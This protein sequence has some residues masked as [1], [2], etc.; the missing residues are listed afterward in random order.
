M[1]Q[2]ILAAALALASSGAA[3]GADPKPEVIHWWT[4]SSEAAAVR[5]IAD[6]YRAAGGVWTD[7]AIAGAD[8]ARAVAVN[9]IVGGN[10]P[11]AAQFNTTKQFTDL[12]EQGMLN[13][14]DDVALREGWDKFL[15]EPVLNV[16][17]VKGHYY[18][19]P[20]N[21]HMQAWI[22][23]SKAA[24]QKAGIS[25]EPASVDELFAALDKLKAAGII[26][27]A[28]GGQ[29]WQENILFLSML[30][31]MGGTDLY[32]KVL[33]ERDPAAINSE[34]FRRVLLNFKRLQSYVDP[35]APGRNWN[36]AT[37]L[38]I[39]GKAGV[40]VMGDWAKGE[41]SAA[42][43]SAGKDYGCI[44]GFGPR[45]PY[46][47]QGDAFVFPKTSNAQQVKYQKLLASVVVAPGT[48]VAFSK[49]K[50]SIPIRGDV[51]S[52]SMDPCARAGM[53]I[54][55]DRTRHVGIGEVYLTPDQN[56][57]MQDVLTAFWNTRMPVEKAQKQIA[58]ALRSEQ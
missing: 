5:T 14:V 35:G 32:L 9:R 29:P 3:F 54:M 52:S 51:D 56:G 39:A 18:A 31:H 13:N 25:K 42:R 11:M 7:T 19:V 10:A 26:P 21:I 46:L 50:G 23:Y 37:A 44:A 58:A 20:V 22:W 12:V 36:D 43:Q 34:A 41:F 33:R 40:Q 55:K 15:P 27:L 8:Q 28:H 57:A 1:K 16:I 4:S 53:A 6:A 47:I 24:F 38:V 17:R 48:Q 49:L 45:S 2:R 30:A